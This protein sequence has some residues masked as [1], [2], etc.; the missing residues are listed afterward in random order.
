MAVDKNTEYWERAL[1]GPFAAEQS[2]GTKSP[3]WRQMTHWDMLNK[4]NSNLVAFFNMSQCIIC[5]PVWR[6]C[7]TWL[8]SCKRPIDQQAN[9]IVVLMNLCV[10]SS[11]ILTLALMLPVSTMPFAR[12][13]VHLMPVAYATTTALLTRSLFVLPIRPHSKTRASFIWTSAIVEV[14][15]PYITQEVVQV[16][17]CWHKCHWQW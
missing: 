5:S 13:S 11:K 7:T 17:K 3:Y 6:F 15:T 8:L 14:T 10:F 1:N 4:E 12:R 16:R 2:R 9:L